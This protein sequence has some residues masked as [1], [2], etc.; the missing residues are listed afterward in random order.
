MFLYF[1]K[2]GK[3]TTAIPHGE[4]PR[5]GNYL[6]IY[7]LLDLDFFDDKGEDYLDWAVNVELAFPD[8]K[9]TIPFSQ[10]EGP[11]QL[12]FRKVSDSEVTF[13]L[14]DG[15]E[16]LTY[17]FRFSPNQA[18]ANAG[19]IDALVSMQKTVNDLTNRG[20]GIDIGLED[21]VYLG[22]A[23]INIE[24]TFGYAK[25]II[26]ES[27]S[28][29]KNLMTTIANVDARKMNRADVLQAIEDKSLNEEEALKLIRENSVDV[30][31]LDI[32][33]SEKY[34]ANREDQ[35]PTSKA[36][37]SRVLSDRL[38]AGKS[39]EIDYSEK[40]INVTVDDKINSSSENPVQ[41]KVVKTELDKKQN[42]INE[43]NKLDY[44]L[45]KNTPYIPKRLSD[46][47]NDKNFIDNTV[48]NLKNYYLKTESYNK[49]EIQKMLSAISS[50]KME[51]VEELPI[52]NISTTTIYLKLRQD[53]E[54]NNI[55][56]E[57]V[58]INEKWE[59][60]G[61]TA[62]K[63]DGLATEEY[64]DKRI[65]DFHPTYEYE[66]PELEGATWFRFA[67]VSDESK[68]SSAIFTM[69]L[70]GTRIV[71]E[72]VELDANYNR[73]LKADTLY[74]FKFK[75]ILQDFYN[76][77]ENGLT[78]NIKI[79]DTSD[80]SLLY[81]KYAYD[82][83]DGPVWI[84]TFNNEKVFDESGSEYL[85]RNALLNLDRAEK[86][87]I[88]LENQN[89]LEG[90]KYDLKKYLKEAIETKYTKLK[91]VAGTFEVSGDSFNGN[92]SLGVNDGELSIS[93]QN[94]EESFV[95]TGIIDKDLD[96]EPL[97]VTWGGGGEDIPN[98]KI[99]F[100]L[101][102]SKTEFE[103]DVPYKDSNERELDLYIHSEQS[104]T[105]NLIPYLNYKV[106]T[107]KDQMLT[108]S[109]FA[110]S[111]NELNGKIISDVLPISQSY[112]LSG[113]DASGGTTGSGD[114]IGGGS[115]GGDMGGSGGGEVGSGGSGGSLYYGLGAITLEQFEKERYVCGLVNFPSTTQ[116][117]D[118]RVKL[119][120]ENNLN[121]KA[122]PE[123]E[124]VDLKEVNQND[125]QLLEGTV[126]EADVPYNFIVKGNLKKFL[127]NKDNYEKGIEIYF[128]AEEGA[129]PEKMVFFT[130]FDIYGTADAP[131]LLILSG[132]ENLPGEEINIYEAEN[133]R[134]GISYRFNN[135]E[136]DVLSKA[137]G[138]LI[139]TGNG[140]INPKINGEEIAY[141]EET[142]TY[143][144]YYE[145]VEDSEV[146]VTAEV[147][148]EN[149]GSYFY[150]LSFLVNAEQCEVFYIEP[151]KPEKNRVI[152]YYEIKNNDVFDFNLKLQEQ[153]L[154]TVSKSYELFSV[155]DKL[156]EV[157]KNANEAISLARGVDNKFYYL[158]DAI[159]N[160][161][162]RLVL[163]TR[164][165][166]MYE[167]ILE[168]S[169]VADLLRDVMNRRQKQWAN[170]VGDGFDIYLINSATNNLCSYLAQSRMEEKWNDEIGDYQ[171]VMHIS[172]SPLILPTDKYPDQPLI[173]K[174][175]ADV[176]YTEHYL[177]DGT[178]DYWEYNI[179]EAMYTAEEYGGSGG[180]DEEEVV[181]I[182]NNNA[183]LVEEL[184]IGTVSSFD[185]NN[186]NQVP[187][188]KAV[189]EYVKNNGVNEND[190]LDIIQ[191]NSEETSA[192][193]VEEATEIA[194][195]TSATFDATSDEQ[196]PTSKAVAGLMASA[197]GSG[198][199]L[200][201]SGVLDL[202]T[203]SDPTVDTSVMIEPALYLLVIKSS[204]T[205][206]GMTEE[207]YTKTFFT[208]ITTQS[209][210]V[211][212]AEHI[213]IDMVDINTGTFVP[214]NLMIVYNQIE[215]SGLFNFM[216]IDENN[217]IDFSTQG[218]NYSYEV[219]KISLIN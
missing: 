199:Q 120:I 168:Y 57:Y 177:D 11:E 102:L 31:T 26:N 64:V 206:D 81:Y 207:I 89:Y 151:Y 137:S 196:I 192:L 76:S 113:T 53:G 136:G 49:E 19:K 1:N 167:P 95:E 63:I 189:S 112:D 94:K 36:V 205:V 35:I 160:L 28:H 125:L 24:K 55:Y 163:E 128:A 92:Y 48:S 184:D 169:N 68:N 110:V 2:E 164:R 114:P 215:N 90:E 133:F 155:F 109:V 37:E 71:E 209:D 42:V 150:Q 27:G 45:V 171:W 186:D 56:E 100:K 117:K 121:F 44:S 7:V 87:F 51:I 101:D 34:D 74:N 194:I 47:E 198:F 96:V 32:G 165:I 152:D 84:L 10:K 218:L 118:L 170:Y 33:T 72:D 131:F 106:K 134:K 13:D 145:N 65:E 88:I 41:N 70:Y 161:Q 38:Q 16:Y 99:S 208:H 93:I 103:I 116:F 39:V 211:V 107:Y 166:L 61:T 123:L 217:A 135:R 82:G 54:E 104:N 213:V 29:F 115:G 122:L 40:V 25:R 204:I 216:P 180:V 78:L 159:G 141:D 143:R 9:L 138:T 193:D 154:H 59:M 119:K 58:Y 202:A 17:Y 21:Y 130:G 79:K 129:I 181:E 144:K 105:Y 111:C 14:V 69:D 200:V 97:I 153:I 52:T 126:L 5:Q 83:P 91:R 219:Y 174:I 139:L 187:T 142:G 22:K 75:G 4:V 179:T 157:D 15:Q 98:L 148:D 183:E 146:K 210:T 62:M 172:I 149:G 140:F 176:P 12:E 175:F 197:G 3:L 46:L 50:L 127:D 67:E 43:E 77:V 212:Q 108:T 156:S 195:G 23:E 185:E 6:N 73:I 60:I 173:G 86:E 85:N 124:K 190:V 214:Y 20:T 30:E 203:S 147:S 66:I 178:P 158:S 80:Y 182:L 18:T 188:S 191:D 8:G 201:G 162:K 132:G